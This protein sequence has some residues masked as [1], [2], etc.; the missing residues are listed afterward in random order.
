MRCEVTT[1]ITITS[2]DDRD[3]TDDISSKIKQYLPSPER[4]IEKVSSFLRLVNKDN[5]DLYDPKVVSF[6]PHHHG[7]PELRCV[8]DYKERAV[9]MF[10]GTPANANCY[11]L[12]ILDMID[13]A[14]KYYVDGATDGYNNEEFARMMFHDACFLLYTIEVAV[15]K[16]KTSVFEQLGYVAFELIIRD[17]FLLENQIPYWI[18]K[19]LI[20]LKY[21]NGQEIL[22]DYCDIVDRNGNTDNSSRGRRQLQIK[23]KNQCL[24]LHLLEA[25]MRKVLIP[26]GDEIVGNIPYPRFKSF[27]LHRLWQKRQGQ[28]NHRVS[29]DIAKFVYSCRSVMDLKEK[30]IYVRPGTSSSSLK[31]IKF[32]SYYFYATLELPIWILGS[33]SKVLL[34][35]MVAYELCPT[36]KETKQEVT[37][38][39]S[40]MKS[41]MDGPKD[42]KELREKGIFFNM[43]GTDEDL[44][45]MFQSIKTYST[46]NLFSLQELRLKIEEHCDSKAKTWIAELLHTYFSSPWTVIALFAATL[47]LCLT[48]LQA[49]YTIH[50]Y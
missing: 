38:C 9:H 23:K 50:P 13:H 19:L 32:R 11:Y 18:L 16:N 6:G 43:L 25:Y 26:G 10:S 3:T 12:K 27:W 29:P 39:I 1:F 40:F 44:V 24:P 45:K 20:C 47:L 37:S 33:G 21:D 14:R 35:N 17:T 34:C 2:D 36:N 48:F 49:Y 22:D 46:E 8:E 4:K 30:G 7:K 31:S 28:Q 15:G 41:L 42:V 5:P